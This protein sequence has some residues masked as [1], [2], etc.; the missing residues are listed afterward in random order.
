MT[1]LVYL[2]GAALAAGVLAAPA[3]AQ[4]PGNPFP[5]KKVDVFLYVDTVNGSSPKGAPKRS[6][7][8]TQSS[9][10]KR[11]EQ[12]VFRV[13]GN[14]AGT[15][16]ILSTANVKYAYVKVPG[17]PNLKLNW[18]GHGAAPNRIWFWTAAWDIPKDYP[19]GAVAYRVVFKTESNKFG[20]FTPSTPLT[21][22]P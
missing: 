8:C 1:R 22:N 16:D 21:V 20:V 7:G 12:L 2:L 15:G 19:L 11:G 6:V 9:Y 13:W 18:G 17:M 3:F 5:G 10:W 4:D 14:E